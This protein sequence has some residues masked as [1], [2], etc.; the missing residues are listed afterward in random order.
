MH[1][2]SGGSN[3]KKQFNIPTSRECARDSLKELRFGSYTAFGYLSHNI[4]GTALLTYLPKWFLRK[5]STIEMK[6][7]V[8]RYYTKKN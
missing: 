5:V 3:V 4:T 1:V 7:L 8:E 6:R 2:E